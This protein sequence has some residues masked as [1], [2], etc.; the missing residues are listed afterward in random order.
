MRWRS[1]TQSAPSKLAKNRPAMTA[2]PDAVVGPRERRNQITALIV[3][4]DDLGKFG[5]KKACFSNDPD[6]GFRAVR[7]GDHAAILEIGLATRMSSQRVGGVRNPG[8]IP[9]RHC[10]AGY[11]LTFVS[12]S[13]V[14]H[15][16]VGTAKIRPHTPQH[17]APNNGK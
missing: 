9:T 2:D 7:P 16:S 17:I 6:P 1:C 15:P 5:R 8:A 10:R 12:G 14:I 13:Q 3:G 4:H 11:W